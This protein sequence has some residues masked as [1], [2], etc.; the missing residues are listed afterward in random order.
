MKIAI[1]MDAEGYT[2]SFEEDGFLKIYEKKGGE[3]EVKKVT[4]YTLEGLPTANAIRNSIRDMGTWM[5]DC[6]VLMA[7]EINGIYFTVFE[8]LKINMWEIEGVGAEFLDYICDSEEQEE[9]KKKT[10]VKDYRPVEK[11]KGKYYINLEEVMEDNQVTSKQVLMPFLK[12]ESFISLEI[13][14]SHV[15]R[16]FETELDDFKLYAEVKRIESGVK[17]YIYKREVEK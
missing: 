15:P 12:E 8:G 6:K 13:D 2:T 17:I 14:C 11:E 4:K 16:W 5:D 10:G 7:R 3:W 1:F 9:K